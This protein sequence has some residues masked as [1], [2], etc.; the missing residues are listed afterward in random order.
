MLRGPEPASRT[1]PSAHR[2]HDDHAAAPARQGGFVGATFAAARLIGG[3]P[4]S[5]GGE[6]WRR[7]GPSPH[8]SICNLPPSR[9][10]RPP[11]RFAWTSSF[12]AP[13][14][15]SSRAPDC[16]RP[17]P[18]ACV[19]CAP[20]NLPIP[21]KPRRHRARPRVALHNTP[22]PN[23]FILGAFDEPVLS[24]AGRWL[25][26]ACTC[27]TCRFALPVDP[28]VDPLKGSSS[29]AEAGGGGGGAGS[30]RAAI[31]C[32]ELVRPSQIA[33]QDRL[34]RRSL[35]IITPRVAGAA[36]RARA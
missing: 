20:P 15:W 11:V 26:T 23:P 30:A 19:R 14:S 33:F 18:I 22:C 31:E 17:M 8:R 3:L 12:L 1:P 34:S 36:R 32:A 25:D 21:V 24:H 29:P 9:R 27:P 10:G 7:W 16:T 35:F 5:A 28:A 6:P 4:P 13:N 2:R